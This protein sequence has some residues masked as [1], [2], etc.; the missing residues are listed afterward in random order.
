MNNIKHS[1]D[2]MFKSEN[3]NDVENKNESF[4]RCAG[5]PRKILT[6]KAKKDKKTRIRTC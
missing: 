1:A 3:F 5:R 6:G 2:I 4:K